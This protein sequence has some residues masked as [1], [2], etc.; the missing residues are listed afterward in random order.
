MTLAPLLLALALPLHAATVDEWTLGGF[1]EPDTRVYPASEFSAA[2][3]PGARSL[4]LEVLLVRPSA[5][6]H[7]A[8]LGELRAAAKALASCGIALGPVEL[9]AART[10]VG[11]DAWAR[12]KME[13][14]D[15]VAALRAAA[16]LRGAAVLLTGPYTDEPETAGFSF[17]EW[18]NG[19]DLHPGLYDTIF[20]SDFMLTQAY[21]DER[22]ASPYTLLAHELLHVILREGRHV[23]GREK[24][25]MN[26]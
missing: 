13:G 2:A 1:S 14:E 16:P 22:A 3:I 9:T 11:R 10:P 7:E 6:T 4:R 26:A 8:V 12:H 19:S 15:T 20:L 21:R 25:L 23:Y 17:A 18:M 24:H 5:W